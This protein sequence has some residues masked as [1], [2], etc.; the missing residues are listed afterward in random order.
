M[1][2]VLLIIKGSINFL[3]NNRLDIA[4]TKSYN[5]RRKLEPIKTVSINMQ[6][7]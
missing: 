5:H 6:I 1:Y 3:N 4:L 7:K 2:F